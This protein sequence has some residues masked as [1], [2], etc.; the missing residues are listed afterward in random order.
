MFLSVPP[1]PVQSTGV[2]TCVGCG[3][4]IAALTALVWA[5]TRYLWYRTPTSTQETKPNG[6]TLPS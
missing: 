1:V 4:L 3:A 5:I 2:G 6:N